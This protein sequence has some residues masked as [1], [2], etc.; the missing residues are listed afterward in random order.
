MSNQR[1]VFSRNLRKLLNSKG[2]DQRVLSEHL[3][4]S[5]MAVSHWVNGTK[6][7]RMTNV[8]RI[9]DYF[10]VKKS[11]LIEE[12]EN[13]KVFTS[14][15][16]NYFPT[17]ISAGIPI[18]VDGIT[19]KD[20]QKITLPDAIMGKWAGN[21]NIYITKINGDSMNNIMPDGSLIAV[22]PVRL[23]QLRNDD[24][25]VYRK[26][27]EYAVKRYFHDTVNN[28]IIF[29]PDSSD[30]RFADDVVYLDDV[31]ELKIKGKVVMWIV[32]AD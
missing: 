9:A 31:E 10:G 26:D 21:K 29:K 3:G 13:K 8:Q 25:V 15:D 20:I 11:D 22:C 6:Y 28:R 27:G 5:E 30:E 32:T 7:P 14:G 2:I 12:H 19:N 1:E 23:D 16:Y 24:I 17:S 4:L 18:E